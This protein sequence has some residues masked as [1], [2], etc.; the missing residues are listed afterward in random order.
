MFVRDFMIRNPIT[1]SLETPISKALDIIIKRKIRHLPVVKD[2]R[3]VGLVTERGLLAVSPS[4]ATTLSV[5]ELNYVLA[6]LTV[7]EALVKDP[8]SVSSDSPI[9]EAAN[10][11]REKKIGSLLVIDDHKLVG[12]VTQTDMVWALVRLFGLRK[13][14]SRI[15]IET[16]DRVGV[17][18][19][20]TEI[21]KQRDIN[22]ISLVVLDVDAE[23]L[24][25]TIRVSVADPQP[26][27]EELEAKGFKI[28]SVN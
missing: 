5:Y 10:V 26:L 6:K 20:I 25:L 16:A 23:R 3:V 9:E 28:V 11:M 17:L 24:H 14:G 27:V 22:I 13:A 2:G 4:P 1:I 7:K 8:V 12:I 19:G 21:V 15:V 18:A